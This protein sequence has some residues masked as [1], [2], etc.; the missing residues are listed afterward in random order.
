MDYGHPAALDPQRLLAQCHVQ[1]GRASGPGGQHRNKVQTAVR[2]CHRPTGMV[3]IGQERRSQAQ[4]LQSAIF[5]LRVNL[6][7][8]VRCPVEQDYLPSVLWRSRCV[9]GR[10]RV[11]VT[12][13]DFPSILAEAMDVI[14]AT[15][16]DVGSASGLLSCSASQLVKLLQAEPRALAWVNQ[17]RLRSGQHAL[18]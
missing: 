1:H 15:A 11:N 12:G 7:L 17:H 3:G 9:A 6:A 18:R 14:A 13:R 16:M 5:R 10:I 4:N 2:V 8:G